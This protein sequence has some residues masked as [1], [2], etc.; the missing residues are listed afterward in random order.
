MTGDDFGRLIYLVLLATVIAG[1]FLLSHRRRLGQVAQQAAIWG[2]I[3]IGV[4]AG[5]GL[6]SDIRN[7]VAPRQTVFADE[8]RIEVPRAP[9]GHYYMTLRINDVP[10]RFVVDTGA[11]DVVLTRD[12]AEKVGIDPQSLQFFGEAHTANGAV[13]TAPVRLDVVELGPVTDRNL[14]AFVNSGEMRES[15]LGMAYLNRFERIEVVRDRMI[16]TR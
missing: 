3:F 16:L 13:R 2:L 11:T 7:D 9:D 15:L 6:W 5:F 4:I 8:N 14:R 1:Y 10:I 12:D